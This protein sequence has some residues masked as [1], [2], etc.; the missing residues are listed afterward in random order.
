MKTNIAIPLNNRVLIPSTGSLLLLLAFLLMLTGCEM[1]IE[2]TPA[3]TAT[4]KA[5]PDQSV[6]VGQTITLDASASADS[7]GN[8]L[9]YQWTILRKPAKSTATLFYSA[10]LKPT[11][12]IDEVGEYEFELTV[13]SA[14]GKSTDRVVV[15]A[16]AAEPLAIITNI[17]VKTTL[18]DRITS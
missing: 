8:P 13:S 11:V 12:K 17:I 1:E 10:S 5:G 4:A 16:S 18:L 9:T 14:N 6:Q 2:I 3:G 15:T 7:D